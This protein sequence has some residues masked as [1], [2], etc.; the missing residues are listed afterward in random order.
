VR[1]DGDF[2]AVEVPADEAE[3]QRRRQKCDQ[4]ADNQNRFH[5]SAAP[6]Y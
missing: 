6:L 5:G 3:H 2:R 1:T 4:H